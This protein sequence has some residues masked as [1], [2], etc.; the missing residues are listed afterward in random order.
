M[1]VCN[2]IL[3]VIDINQQLICHTFVA[4]KTH[5]TWIIKQIFEIIET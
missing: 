4:D 5:I 1:C 2:I 3:F